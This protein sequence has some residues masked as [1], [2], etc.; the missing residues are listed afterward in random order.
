MAQLQR[1]FPKKGVS[2]SDPP[3]SRREASGDPGGGRGGAE[4]PDPVKR[5]TPPWAELGIGC[6]SGKLLCSQS[7]ALQPHL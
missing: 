3:V 6:L 2:T 7:P 1:T 4:F 5:R